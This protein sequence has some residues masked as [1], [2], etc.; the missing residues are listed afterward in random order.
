MQLNSDRNL[1]FTAAHSI[2]L[3]LDAS[4]FDGL[5][6]DLPHDS[7][8]TKNIILATISSSEFAQETTIATVMWVKLCKELMRC[9]IHESLEWEDDTSA[10]GTMEQLKR[11]TFHVCSVWRRMELLDDCCRTT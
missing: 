8:Q 4:D 2:K 1:I 7:Q 9:V 3:K 10:I 5:L 11:E 6:V